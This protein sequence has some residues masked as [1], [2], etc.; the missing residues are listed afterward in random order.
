ML[1][2][3]DFLINIQLFKVSGILPI[4]YITLLFSYLTTYNLPVK[5]IFFL[6][7]PQF[8]AFYGSRS[9]VSRV[10]YWSRSSTS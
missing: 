9:L 10:R 7:G 8:L 1:L 3:K 6:N 5:N 2:C 4:H